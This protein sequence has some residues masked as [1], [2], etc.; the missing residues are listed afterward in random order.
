MERKRSYEVVIS[1]VHAGKVS[2]TEGPRITLKTL[3]LEYSSKTR[4][5][6]REKGRE[7]VHARFL[8]E[9]FESWEIETAPATFMI[10]ERGKG[11]KGKRVMCAR[12]AR[13]ILN[14]T[15]VAVYLLTENEKP[16]HAMA[17]SVAAQK[18][19]TAAAA[20]VDNVCDTY[21][22]YYSNVDSSCAA[23]SQLLLLLLLYISHVLC[24]RL[25]G[26]YL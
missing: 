26:T 20:A 18:D 11:L 22:T 17:H 5:N 3:T 8:G 19:K 15:D 13:A 23:P 21:R 10:F 4:R 16:T 9:T 2:S 6:R 7:H 1:K 24:C 12:I 25:P 14:G